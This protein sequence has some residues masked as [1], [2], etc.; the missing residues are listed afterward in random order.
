M[1]SF[2]SFLIL[3]TAV[4]VVPACHAQS[5]N[6][7]YTFPSGSVGY[8]PEGVPY[9]GSGGVL[10]GTT[11]FGG[12]NTPCAAATLGCGTAFSL[13][14]PAQSGNPWTQNCSTVSRGRRTARSQPLGFYRDPVG[15][16]SARQRWVAPQARTVTRDAALYSS[17]RHRFKPSV[18]GPK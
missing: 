6:V 10:F 7:I 12:A 2:V 11:A 4:N 16:Y 13:T 15:L 3:L 1:K 18:L 8:E 5:F 17:S 9:I 14:P